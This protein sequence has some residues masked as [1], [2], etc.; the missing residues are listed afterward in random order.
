MPSMQK[1]TFHDFLDESVPSPFQ[2]TILRLKWITLVL[3]KLRINIIKFSKI[4]KS[5]QKPS[6]FEKY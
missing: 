5:K 3:K 1:I 6:L 4:W 2:E